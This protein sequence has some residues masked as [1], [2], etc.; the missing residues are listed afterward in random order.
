MAVSEKLKCLK[1]LA[2]AEVLYRLLGERKFLA[3][4]LKVCRTV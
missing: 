2:C 1:F 3:F 4:D